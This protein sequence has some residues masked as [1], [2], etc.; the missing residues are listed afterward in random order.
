MGV[1]PGFKLVQ[2]FHDPTPQSKINIRI[3]ASM[4]EIATKNTTLSEKEKE[5]FMI[6]LLLV[7]R[8][9]VS[10]WNHKERFVAE[11]DRLIGAISTGGLFPRTFSLSSTNSWSRSKAPSTI[12]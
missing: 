4:L 5:Q 6:I 7:A 9:M 12:L 3:V 10:V 1:P 8:K 2:I 11:Q